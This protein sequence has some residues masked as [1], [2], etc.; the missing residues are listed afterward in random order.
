MSSGE[1]DAFSRDSPEEKRIIH[2]ITQ[3]QN[4]RYDIP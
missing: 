1:P 4:A 3:V 2:E